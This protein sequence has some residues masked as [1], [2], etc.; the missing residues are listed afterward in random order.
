M[1]CKWL[2]A[3]RGLLRAAAASMKAAAVAAEVFGAGCSFAQV[4]ILRSIISAAGDSG[5][6]NGKVIGCSS[7]RKVVNA[8]DAAAVT[9]GDGGALEVAG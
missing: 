8:G 1:G 2:S 9:L 4:M 5:R 3:A 6:D 7:G